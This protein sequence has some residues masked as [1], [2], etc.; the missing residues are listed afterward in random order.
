[1]DVRQ[2]LVLATPEQPMYRV[3]HEQRLLV[4][5]Q[6]GLDDL[7]EE[8]QLGQIHN[9][10]QRR[11]RSTSVPTTTTTTIPQKTPT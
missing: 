6:H 7:P 1:M 3:S 11:G 10:L 9:S 4:G 5:F 8:G 2:D